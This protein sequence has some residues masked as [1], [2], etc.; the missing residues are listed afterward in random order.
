[1]T[2]PS[3]NGHKR[4]MEAADRIGTPLPGTRPSRAAANNARSTRWD[5]NPIS[6]GTDGGQDMHTDIDYFGMSNEHASDCFGP[7]PDLA[8]LGDGGEAFGAS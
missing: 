8:A 1:M 7:P 6:N 2:I 5:T 4:G 3:G